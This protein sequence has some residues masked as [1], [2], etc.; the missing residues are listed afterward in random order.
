[1]FAWHLFDMVEQLGPRPTR[2]SFTYRPLN[3]QFGQYIL[4]LMNLFLL[5]SA[6]YD[7]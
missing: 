7:N 1:M 3:H 2:K 4:F 6:V 5:Q